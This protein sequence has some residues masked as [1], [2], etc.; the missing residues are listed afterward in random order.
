MPAARKNRPL[1]RPRARGLWALYPAAQVADVADM[2]GA[3]AMEINGVAHV[4]LTVG[5]YEACLP[6]YEK[7]LPFLGLTFVVRKTGSQF[8]CIGGRTGMGIQKARSNIAASASRRGARIASRM[9]ACARAQRRRRGV[10]V[11][12]RDR[13]NGHPS[14][15]RGHLGQGLL[16][17]CSKTPTHPVGSQ[18]YPG[19]GPAG[20]IAAPPPGR[21]ERASSESKDLARG[22]RKDLA[23]PRR[24]SRE[25]C[26]RVRAATA[27]QKTEIKRR[28]ARS[29]LAGAP[30]WRSGER[31]SVALSA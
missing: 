12:A 9:P 13:R 24:I 20:R 7:L 15:R 21:P 25:P 10:P 16:L 19:Q 26:A 8:Y 22:P 31:E 17:G 6:F 27:T 2:E 30:V 3:K 14:A 29:P 28:R 5:D 11:P 23:R 1:R 4:M 18:S